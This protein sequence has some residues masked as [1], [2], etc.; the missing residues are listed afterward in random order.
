M[1]WLF[2]EASHR[3]RTA[4]RG[5]LVDL[6]TGSLLSGLQRVVRLRTIPPNPHFNPLN[7][8]FFLTGE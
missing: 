6:E 5:V 2:H 7:G 4:R 1:G 3:S 8:G